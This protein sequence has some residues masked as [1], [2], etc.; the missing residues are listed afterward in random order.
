MAGE[1]SGDQHAAHLVENLKL[2][3]EQHQPH[4]HF[5]FS[6]IGGSKMQEAGVTLIQDLT[7]L[8]VMGLTEVIRHLKVIRQIFKQMEQHLRET[9]PDLLILVDYPG[10]NLRLA[11]KAKSMGIKVLYYISPQLWA[12]KPNRIKTI[13]QNVDVMA[14]ILPFE[15]KIYDEANFPSYFVGHPLSETVKTTLSAEAVRKK[16][17]LPANKKI[18]G[19]LPGSRPGEIK[20][21]FPI[22]LK[23]AELLNQ[24]YSDLIFVLPLAPTLSEQSFFSYCQKSSLP[25]RFIPSGQNHYDLINT[26]HSLIITSGTATL[27]T[28]L[29]TRPMVI[30]YKTSRI[31]Y[32]IAS[33]VIRIKYIGLSNLLANKMVVPEII[34]QDLTP[35]N[36]FCAMQR[37]I[38][39]PH[40]YASVQTQLQA[41]K[42]SLNKNP[43]EKSL[44]DLVLDLIGD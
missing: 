27:E 39:D 36:L 9:K 10:F 8:N 7:H 13:K 29:L 35:K 41:V 14:T 19:L 34:Q 38:D 4:W 1:A 44:A 16:Y 26:C 37:F 21:I 31:N 42:E 12:W 22:M 5:H 17:D 6:G 40:Y 32:T 3:N 30:V 20:R 23:A 33:Q 24:H 25:I 11:K 43:S 15:K 2:S 18:I 28:A